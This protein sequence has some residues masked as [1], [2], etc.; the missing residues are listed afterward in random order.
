MIKNIVFDFGQ[1]LVDY[2]FPDFLASLIED[3]QE[4][5]KFGKIFCSREFCDRCDRGEETF[6]EIINKSRQEYP[7]WDQLLVELG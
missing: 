2:D 7:Q 5:K 3:E 1:V 4:R 6:R